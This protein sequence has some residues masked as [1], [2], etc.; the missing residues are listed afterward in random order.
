MKTSFKAI[1]GN[2]ATAIVCWVYLATCCSL[3]SAST[4]V[5]AWGD[6]TYGQ[7]VVPSGLTNVIKIAQGGMHGLAINRDSTVTAWGYNSNATTPLTYV[8]Q[9][10]S[11]AGLS[12]VV[13]IAAGYNSSTAL[14]T[15]GSVVIWGDPG[16]TNLP[17]GLTN[18]IAIASGS[19]E[20]IALRN[21]GTVFAWG[22]NSY[23]QTNIPSGLTN[24]IGVSSGG[25][26]NVALLGNGTACIWGWNG[27]GQ[28]NVP[29]RATNVIAVATGLYHVMAL[30]GDSTVVVWGY[31]GYGQTNVPAGLSNVVQIAAGWHH[32]LALK[33]DGSVTAWGYNSAG[34]T[35][36]PSGLSNVV[37]VSANRYQSLAL[38][39]DGSP[40]VLNQPQSQTVYS[41]KNASFNVLV[42]G[43]TN[44]N[45]QWQFNGANIGGATNAL[46]TL[47]NLQVTG[48]GNYAAV[49]SNSIGSTISSTGLLS[50]ITSAP[51]VV[52]LPANQIVALRSNSFIT[53]SAAGSLPLNYQWQFNGTNILKATNIVLS[54]TNAQWT[55]EGNYTVVITNAY[56]SI[57]SPPS[58]LNV[59]DLGEAL[60]ATNLTW[61]T[62]ASGPWFPEA[63]V[64]H[65]GVVAAQS[66]SLAWPQS[67]TLQTT[68]S[69]PGTLVFW[70]VV[71]QYSDTLLFSSSGVSPQS[72][73]TASTSWQMRTVY[74]GTGSQSLQWTFKRSPFNGTAQDVGWLDQVSFVPGGTAPFITSYTGGQSVPAGTNVNLAINVAGTPPFNTQWQF[75]GTN[76][77]GATN[78]TLAIANVQAADGGAYG[79]MITNG[80]GLVSSNL[81]LTV[82]PAV[83]TLIVQ[84]TNQAIW[85]RGN[86]TFQV[87]AQGSMPFSY[88]WRFNGAN[89]D[90]AT[91]A[92]FNLSGLQK[93]NAGIYTVVVSNE[94]GSTISSNARL[95]VVTSGVV[96]WGGNASGDTN[97]SSACINP[98]AV[99]AGG[100]GAA[101]ALA[102]NEDRT[103]VGWGNNNY[104]QITIPADLTNVVSI[105]LEN[106]DGLALKADGTVAVWGANEFGQTGVP[107]RLANV[108]KIAAGGWHMLAL[109]ADGTVAGYGYNNYGQADVPAA[110]EDVIDVAC[111][112]HCSVAL[113]GSG[114]IIAWGDN[115]LSQTNVPANLTNVI[116][117]AASFTHCLALKSD[118]T[119]AVWGGEATNIPSGLSNVVAIASASTQCLALKSDGTAVIW[120]DNTYGQTNIP[121][122]ISNVVGLGGGNDFSLLIVNDGSPWIVRPPARRTIYEGYDTTFSVTAM[123]V[124]PISYQWQFNGTNITGATN[125]AINLANLQLEQQGGYQVVVSNALGMSVNSNAYLTIVP[126]SPAILIPPASQSLLLGGTASFSVRARG[127]LPLNYHWRF[128]GINIDG[129]TNDSFTVSNVQPVNLGNYDVMIANTFGSITSAPAVLTPAQIV[130]WGDN[131]YGQTNV[132]AGLSNVVS[133][134][135]GFWHTLAL[136]NDG[137]VS[138]W[139]ASTNNLLAIV[140]FGQTSV[141]AGLSNVRAVAAGG[142]TS[143]ALKADGTIVVW[144][145]GGDGETNISHGL[146][147]VIALAAGYN[148]WLALRKDGTVIAWGLNADGQTNVP[149]GLTNVIAVAAGGYHSL[150]LKSDGTVVAWGNYHA[151][152]INV[153]AG[154][155]NVVAVAG[156]AY[157]SLA[158]KNTGDIVAWGWNVTGQ[159]TIPAEATNVIAIAGGQLHSMALKKSGTVVCWGYDYYV[160]NPQYPPVVTPLGLPKVTTIGSGGYS[161]TAL[162]DYGNPF[163]ASPLKDQVIY[164]GQNATFST[165]ASGSEPITYQW[166][167]NGTNLDGA[168]NST[169]NLTNV[170]LSAA[171][172]Y[173]ITVSNLFGS[174]VGAS[175]N[176]TVLRSTPQFVGVANSFCISSNGLNMQ[177]GG[178]SG[179]GA[180]I[181]YSSTN[182]VS[183]LPIFT[184]PPVTGFFQFTDSNALNAPLLFYRAAEQ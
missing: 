154:L 179:H 79:V 168:I 84:P 111:G 38:T 107:S 104:G 43:R 175:A 161:A 40:W 180:V 135:A 4:S 90:G 83:P 125:A 27:Y 59:V 182:L 141:P 18:I 2:I 160:S 72:A 110:L 184:N 98:L 166:Q 11:P 51:I 81:L 28:T 108:T 34:Q 58:F 121:P 92:S 101:G 9:A 8:G 12:N 140:D 139:G 146:T 89:I 20:S 134:A 21:D 50:V 153:P 71:Y 127:V 162:L 60:N 78:L 65:D 46:L 1:L 128:N 22:S 66:G 73:A 30:R 151:G 10:V 24:V 112:M 138:A 14:K 26:D 32:C 77:A 16:E 87:A 19:L 49:V 102:L 129:A 158:L 133:I 82:T 52:T 115:S 126:P 63:G 35:T 148:H 97:V 163:V 169:L 99:T 47:T 105:A 41:G 74:L 37:A 155:S 171:G 145:Y 55:N 75:N 95:W 33:K 118:G 132:P 167:F 86:A 106:E 13:A 159:I 181:I 7:T 144:G 150:A 176:L 174:V 6:N 172:C 117:I 15:D 64:N 170:P 114:S 109:K 57:T 164:S 25:P 88:Q 124:P 113:T 36:I 119:V 130:A 3:Y 183:W 44:L 17:I 165:T 29:A 85:I 136:K 157:H 122:G 123:G 177:L 5:V 149:V 45:Y 94:P 103:V 178:L 173:Q 76:I 147:N 42:V 53:V 156:G 143:L 96:A 61:T 116:S 31:N 23:G 93:T 120:G 131:S 56:G 48:S 54:I 69:G 100:G 91:N 142:N 137:T 67:S 70:W 68:V 80:Y 39:N 152:Q 62:S